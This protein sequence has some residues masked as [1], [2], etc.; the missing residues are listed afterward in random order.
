MKAI[1]GKELHQAKVDTRSSRTATTTTTTATCWMRAW[2]AVMSSC[3]P[4]RP[5]SARAWLQL[6]SSSC[7][8]STGTSAGMSPFERSQTLTMTLAS[9]RL[10]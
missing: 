6:S 3:R 7:R 9:R 1:V 2:M 4:W 10:P 8:T 5:I